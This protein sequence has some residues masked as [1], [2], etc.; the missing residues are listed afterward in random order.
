MKHSFL[1]KKQSNGSFT[2]IF[3]RR[4]KSE[5]K[6]EISPIRSNWKVMWAVS[7][8]F[9]VLFSVK[10]KNRSEG[11]QYA[12]VCLSSDDEDGIQEQLQT[13]F[14]RVINFSKFALCSNKFCD[15]A[16]PSPSLLKYNPVKREFPP[17]PRK[18][19]AREKI[20]SKYEIDEDQV[21]VYFD[22]YGSLASYFHFA[23]I[24]KQ[25]GIQ[26]K[27]KTSWN[28]YFEI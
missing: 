11:T 17:P 27:K 13:S 19:T 7:K 25:F 18:E 6:S 10:V 14:E 24:S 15:E 23:L 12:P 5:L 26:L 20:M 28:W 22:E 2:G 21:A 8:Q 9:S 3:D 1:A 16:F 4:I